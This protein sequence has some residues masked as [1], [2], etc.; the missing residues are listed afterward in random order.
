LPHPSRLP[1][2]HENDEV[3]QQ[4]DWLRVTLASIGDA[5]ITTDAD[6]RVTFLNRVAETLTGWPQHEAVGRPLSEVFR[7]VNETTR[8][9]VDD[10]AMLAVREGRTVG[11]ANHTVLIA[12]DGTECPIDDSAAP[13]LGDGNT[14]MGTVLVFRDISECRRA[15]EARARL[16]AIVESSDDA[17]VSKTLEGII[18]SWN[19]GA[20]RLFGY[21]EAEAVGQHI[22]LIIPPDRHE[23][24]QTILDRLRRGERIDHFETV[25]QAK[26]G[27]LLNISLTV[28]PIHDGAGR[29][30]GASKIARDTTTQKRA[31]AS[32][33][34]LASASAALATVVDYE[35]TLN[36]VAQV[37]VPF[38]ADWCVIDI[39]QP[40][41]TLRRI[42]VVHSDP[43]RVAL[44]EAF[45]RRY[46]PPPDAAHGTRY[47]LRT[48]KSD[49]ITDITDAMLTGAARDDEHLRMLRQLHLRSSICVPL[50][51]RGKTLGAITFVTAESERRY[52]T[53]DLTVAEDL[54]H[55][56]TIA[57]E[58]ARLYGELR[59]ADRRKN[60]FLALLA[61]ELR[62][63]LA[64][65][66]N[67]LQILRLAGSNTQAIAQARTMMDRQLG[68]MVRLIDDLLDISRISQNKMELRKDRVLLADVI[69][70]AV[71][72]A[73]SLIEAARH[74]L[75]VHQPTG[76]V[77]L[78]ADL[79]RLA[80]VFG[81]LL[82]NSAKYTEPGGH[83]WLSAERTGREVIVS[84]RDTGIGI[85]ADALPR[86]F[87]MFSQVDRSIE[88]TT[89]GL[90]IGLALV[91]GL[92]EMHGGTVSADSPGLGQGSTFTVRLPALG[93]PAAATD[94]PIDEPRGPTG[95][96]RRILVVDDN[97]DSAE[98]MAMMLQLTGNEVT[99]AHDGIAA[100]EA[101]ERVR[102]EVILMDVGMP[103]LN[104]YEATR[105]IREQPW[106]QG[107]VIIALTGWGQDVD[108][109]QSRQAGCDGHLVKP[110]ALADLDKLL[111]TLLPGGH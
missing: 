79:T 102:P 62:N 96:A 56:A 99:T 43:A 41:G 76:P 10:P 47:V 17:I 87:D 22:T 69:S 80:Q 31:L 33:Q 29:V 100:V 74:E 50:R 58:N 90:G 64:P 32:A 12:R 34:F 36:K 49:L 16:A 19:V 3:R 26:D 70:S 48:G 45:H 110:I 8:Q 57:I 21:T 1:L 53:A 60:E 40:D 55:R 5:V 24:E 92:V 44:G 46:P 106:G 42:A 6:G 4:S 81:N 23:E 93:Q 68:H 91:K 82:T 61:H 86:I 75:T 18:R 13:M 20:E 73:R 11:L 98:S 14:P 89:G 78:D 108:R 94:T 35:S 109:V 88:R 84:V 71:E 25:R 65:L 38:F 107:T 105:R 83:I 2:S 103:R 37:A 59:E 77:F 95:P 30:I 27:R 15:D 97:R 67:G 54:A 7:V 101:A 85:P 63:P 72:A 51:A 9:R 52:G 39:V 28:S 66:R 111:A 104:G